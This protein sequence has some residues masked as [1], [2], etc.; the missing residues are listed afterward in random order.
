MAGT[1]FFDYFDVKHFIPDATARTT[2]RWMRDRFR[3]SRHFDGEKNK[4]QQSDRLPSA[5][6]KSSMSFSSDRHAKKLKASVDKLMHIHRMTCE[7]AHSSCERSFLSNNG[8]AWIQSLSA[9]FTE[10]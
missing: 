3:L 6:Q 9:G 5:S 2:G 7:E 8:P 4:R 10:P 1:T